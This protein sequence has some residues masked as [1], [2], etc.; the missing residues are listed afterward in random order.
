MEI[1][2]WCGKACT[3]LCVFEIKT[4]SGVIDSYSTKWEM[5]LYSRLTVSLGYNEIHF[6]QDA[7]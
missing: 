7:I 6:S 1:P 4:G 3:A 5:H 2:L